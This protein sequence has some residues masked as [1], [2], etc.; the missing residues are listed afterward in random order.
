MKTS[1]QTRTPKASLAL[2]LSALVLA[3]TTGANPQ[4]SESGS[5]AS[6]DPAKFQTKIFSKIDAN[7]DG[8]LDASELEASMLARFAKREKRKQ[9]H[10]AKRAKWLEE[11]GL[12]E[13]DMKAFHEARKEFHQ[14]WLEKNPKLAQAFGDGGFGKGP[15][16]GPSKGPGK[17]K[18]KGK[19]GHSRGAKLDLDGDGQVSAQEVT[20]ASYERLAKMDQDGNGTVSFEEFQASAPKG[21]KGK[22]G[23]RGFGRKRFGKGQKKGFCPKNPETE[24]PSGS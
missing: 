5:P 13:E 24:A 16:F 1:N 11:K 15:G 10:Q 22:H 9:E 21:R 6:F 20:Q 4:E 14:S 17:G 23:R 18:G 12:S 19:G 2:A 7:Q 3:G 8:Q